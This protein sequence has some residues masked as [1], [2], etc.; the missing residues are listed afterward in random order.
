MNG[1]EQRQG[2]ER[3]LGNTLALGF[4]QVFLVFMP[5]AVPFFQSKG[6]DMQEIFLLQAIFATVIHYC[7]GKIA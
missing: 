2:L 4:F 3:N 6:L 1:R 5:I 7:P